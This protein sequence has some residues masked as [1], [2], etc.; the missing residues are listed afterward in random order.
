MTADECS[1]PGGSLPKMWTA[2]FLP[3][4]PSHTLPL[5]YQ[6]DELK[7]EILPAFAEKQQRRFHFRKGIKMKKN[8]KRTISLLL[9]FAVLF[10]AVPVAYAAEDTQPEET[11]ETST[12]PPETEPE[13]TEVTL[14]STVAPTEQSSPEETEAEAEIDP[15]HM[16]GPLEIVSGLWNRIKESLAATFGASTYAIGTKATIQSVGN[17]CVQ[18][19]Y[20]VTL[21]YKLK[22]GVS[23][24]CYIQGITWHYV[25]STTNPAL[26]LE[27]NKE[28]PYGTGGMYTEDITFYTSRTGTTGCKAWDALSDN[29]KRAIA[30][31]ALYGCPAGFWDSQGMTGGNLLNPTNPNQAC[32]CAA[33]IMTWEIVTGLRSDTPPYE[34]LDSKLYDAYSSK[35]AVPTYYNYLSQKLANH[36]AEAYKYEALPSPEE[37]EYVL[38]YGISSKQTLL[39]VSRVV[40]RTPP[41]EP[42]ETEPD[43]SGDLSIVKTT[44]DGQNLKGWK[45]AVYS[46]SACT[47][48]VAGPCTTNASGK[49][50]IYEMDVG[51]YYVK[52]LGHT[53][54]AINSQ[55]YCASTNP[56]KVTIRDGE[57]TTVRFTNKLNTGGVQIIKNTNTG[58]NR[59]G[60]VIGLYTDSACTAPVSGSPFTTGSDGT[61][62]VSGLTPGTLYAKELPSDD[63][64][65]QCDTDVKTVTVTANGTASVSFNNTHNGR[66]RV[67]KTMATGGPLSGW[68]FAIRDSS[69]NAISGSPFITDDNG[70]ILTGNLLPGKYTVEE[71]LPQDSP[72][73]CVGEISR[74]ITVTAGDTAE[75]SFT[76]TMRPGKIVVEKKDIYG[77]PLAGAEFLLEWSED[78]TVWQAI[79]Y[80]EKDAAEKGGCSN[81]ALVNGR[82]TTGADGQ[83]EWGNL[84]PS[85]FYRLTETKAPVGF[86]L[87]ADTAYEGKLPTD[88]DLTLA[89]R[90]VNT[91]VYTL[92]ETGSNT[93]HTLSLLSALAMTMGLAASLLAASKK[94]KH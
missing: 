23:R 79:H 42:T 38:A 51:T 30:L 18:G 53:D 58:G 5:D 90:V 63:L 89:I 17:M 7:K 4:S 12:A 8:V 72:Y 9:A 32:F 75:V 80:S 48:L 83:L 54:S 26:C 45:F 56:Q 22:D 25:D 14:E 57:V 91:R 2:S 50:S 68:Q 46:D 86:N 65:W 78:G 55:Y 59:N 33:Q 36:D 62:M 19:A 6:L 27:P 40:N 21:S 43:P 1:F 29:Q 16:K 13:Q 34:Q 76:N 28:C 20:K 61:V 41:A 70:V 73:V 39:Y 15:A 88:P 64:Y 3:F 69:G 24:S 92:P 10:A 49:R 44:E 31:I 74:E 52:E 87:L 81:A 71:Q 37:S 11:Q 82:L 93:L 85:L 94:K 35:G 77:Q 67:V 60:W 47:N 66:I 84:H